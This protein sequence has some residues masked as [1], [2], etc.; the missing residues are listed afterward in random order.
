MHALFQ[1]GPFPGSGFFPMWSIPGATVGIRVTFSLFTWTERAHATQTPPITVTLS[2]PALRLTPETLACSLFLEHTRCTLHLESSFH[3]YPRGSSS[4]HWVSGQ[5]LPSQRTFPN[6]TSESNPGVPA[7]LPLT[8]QPLV[9]Y[10]FLKDLGENT[11]G[12]SFH[13]DDPSSGQGHRP[14]LSPAS[15]H[16]SA[17]RVYLIQLASLEKL[18]RLH[19]LATSFSEGICFTQGVPEHWSALDPVVKG[20][21]PLRGGL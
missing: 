11:A 9:L 7:S 10:F 19:G 20:F 13:M 15:T 14:S 5:M 1:D 2:L 12:V 8:F 17:G 3:K 16:F 18:L 6:H 21:A 4:H